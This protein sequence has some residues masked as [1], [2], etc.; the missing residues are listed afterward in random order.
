MYLALL[1][2]GLRLYMWKYHGGGEVG[3][4]TNRYSPSFVKNMTSLWFITYS[5]SVKKGKCVTRSLVAIILGCIHLDLSYTLKSQMKSGLK[6]WRE[7]G[8]KHTV[9]IAWRGTFGRAHSLCLHKPQ[10][11][12]VLL[13]IQFQ[14]WELELNK[15]WSWKVT[16]L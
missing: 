8:K 11:F 14:S 12:P 16:D 3:R 13:Y 7:G 9:L 1:C 2:S 10:G 4:Y 5:P 6:S 15:L